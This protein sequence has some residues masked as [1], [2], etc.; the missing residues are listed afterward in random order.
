[1]GRVKSLGIST[2][3]FGLKERASVDLVSEKS[4]DIGIKKFSLGK[5]PWYRSSFVLGHR[6]EQVGHLVVINVAH[7][8]LARLFCCVGDSVDT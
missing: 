5:M 8:S 2:G 3:N 1:M 7:E 4:L 6:L